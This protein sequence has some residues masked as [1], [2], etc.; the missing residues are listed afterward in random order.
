MADRLMQQN[1]GP[2]AAQHHRHHPCRRIDRGKIQNRFAS[3][4]PGIAQKPVFFLIEFESNPPTAAERAYLPIAVFFS[5]A[6]HL[7]PG[8]RL[9]VSDQ[10]AIGR[11]HSHYLIFRIKG[12]QHIGDARI[13]PPGLGIDRIQQRDPVSRRDLGFCPFDGIEIPRR[14]PLRRNR[15]T[16]VTLGGVR[17]IASRICGDLQIFPGQFVRVGKPG[18]LSGGRPDPDSLGNTLCRAL[19]DPLF[20]GDGLRHPRLEVE[21]RIIH[22][23]DIEPVKGLEHFQIRH[24]EFCEL[25]GI[26]HQ[27]SPFVSGLE[28]ARSI[29]DSF[30]QP[31]CNAS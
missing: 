18:F 27:S 10:R 6:G 25:S 29:A 31:Q 14:P 2:T 9:H 8:Q 13:V 12:G 5:D 4:F 20:H 21:I 1:T 24:A 22:I 16:P 19:D 11:R 3:R 17:N 30:P 15:Q 28:Q 26:R 7:K 23:P